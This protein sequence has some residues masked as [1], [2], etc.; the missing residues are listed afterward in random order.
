M[1]MSINEIRVVAKLFYGEADAYDKNTPYDQVV[2]TMR[3]IDEYRFQI[4][5]EK[6]HLNGYTKD[7]ESF[8]KFMES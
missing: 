2:Q 4:A 8:T 5:R 3:D 1:S 6:C 7:Y